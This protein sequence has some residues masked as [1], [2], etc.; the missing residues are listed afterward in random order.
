M[1]LDNINTDLI[2]KMGLMNTVVKKQAG[3]GLEFQ[4]MMQAMLQNMAQVSEDKADGKIMT[5]EVGMKLE[6]LKLVLKGNNKY[7]NQYVNSSIKDE[8][9]VDK[10]DK[11]E[12][13]Y[14]NDTKGQ[15]YKAVDK[16]SKVYGVDRK[17]VLAVIKAESNFNPKC[18]SSAGAMG[19]MQLMPVNVKEEGITDP[20]DID[21][22]VRGGVSELSKHLKRYKGN[23]EMA[24]MAYNAGAGTVQ[25]RGVK[26][27]EDLYKMP[28]ETRN[29]VPKV[30]KYHKTM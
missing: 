7:N 1:K 9:K 20:F 21:Q 26:G 3:D 11:T 16:Y 4:I 22:N 30:L 15:I 25:R 13:S 14:S 24:L 12:G 29:Y 19:V 6:D 28:K 5:T 8:I 27:P 17:L 23:V 2:M 18:V 10:T